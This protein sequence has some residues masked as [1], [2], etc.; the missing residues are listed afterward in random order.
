M[1]NLGQIRANVR[2]EILEPT[3]GFWT[4]SEIN[5]FINEACDDLTEAA[6]V[7]AGPQSITL[8]AGTDNYALA[9][10]FGRTR[11]VERETNVGSGLYTPLRP[12]ELADRR[13]EKA[14]P[15]AYFIYAGRIYIVPTPDAAYGLRVW[16]YA[17]ATTLALDTDTPTFPAR[18]HRLA[19][20][21]AVAQC[22]RKQN[23]PAYTTY[24]AD[25]A[26]G[27]ADMVAK[28]AMR[29]QANGFMVVRDDWAL[30]FTP[31]VR[32]LPAGS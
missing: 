24:I 12:A 29:S 8:V 27:R 18:F 7:E 6:R 16:Y 2:T 19:E 26:S 31:D 5:R 4:D 11:Y 20:L 28:L 32:T 15:T 9:A 23:D 25:Y 22:K 3:A 30:P 10:D 17:A 1:S 13:S 14:I 21:F